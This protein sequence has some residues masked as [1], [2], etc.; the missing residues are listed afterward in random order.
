MVKLQP[1]KAADIREKL[2]AFA[3]DPARPNN[4]LKILENIANG[5][6]LR[7]GDWRVSFTLDA[8]AGEIEVFEV[9]PRGG[10]YRW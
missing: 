5:F 7:V 2:A 4:N 8:E 1:A 10:A 9:A 6:R 3:A